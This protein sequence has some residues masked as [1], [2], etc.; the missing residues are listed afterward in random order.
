M[1]IAAPSAA[2]SI[3]PWPGRPPLGE[4]LADNDFG[5][6]IPNLDDDVLLGKA[7]RAGLR[8]I[9]LVEDPDTRAK[10]TPTEPYG[11]KRPLISND[12]YPAFN[13]PQV[14]L[15]TDPIERITPQGV[16]TADGQQTVLLC[17]ILKDAGIRDALTCLVLCANDPVAAWGGVKLLRD[18]FH[19]EPAIVTGTKT[20]RYRTIAMR[21]ASSPYT[22]GYMGTPAR[23]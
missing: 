1:A 13:L 11:C 22:T 10:L 19:I 3:P 12:W 6:E 15:V 4:A 18:D 17:A 21:V 2:R 20:N 5:R 16:V 9:A 7:E 8:N 14:E 23:V